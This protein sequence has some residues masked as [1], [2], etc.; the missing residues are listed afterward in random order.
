MA[1]RPRKKLHHFCENNLANY[2]EDRDF[3]ARGATSR[4]SPHLHFGEIS[5][6]QLWHTAQEY[7]LAQK[8]EQSLDHFL[9]EIAWR[10]FSYSLLY[11]NPA[12]PESPLQKRFEAFAWESPDSETL[13]RW[14]KG[15]TGYPIV[16]AGMRELWATGSMHNRVRMIVGSFLVKD[17]RYHWRIGEDWFWD[18]LVDADLASNAASWQ[19]IAGCGADAAP[20]FRIFNPT[21]QG[22]KFDPTGEYIAKWAP[23]SHKLAPIVS[24]AHARNKALEAFKNLP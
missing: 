1:K 11:H 8:C 7:G 21:T 2:K 19:W 22:E 9:S 3:P 20:Y 14:Q 6:H 16:D 18:T 10:E 17:L 15:M 13:D 23:D 5:P 4:L 24:H 12:L